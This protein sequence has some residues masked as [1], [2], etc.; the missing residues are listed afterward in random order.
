MITVTLFTIAKTWKQPNFPLT[1]DWIKK[2]WHTYRAEFYSVI[3]KNG[4]MSFA[5]NQMDLENIILNKV[6]QKSYDITYMWNIKKLIQEIIYVTE[7]DPQTQKTN[8]W[9]VKV[10][11]EGG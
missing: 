4:I 8:L 3:K 1:E 10:K 11:G 7:T 2:M 9:L 5:A 6:S